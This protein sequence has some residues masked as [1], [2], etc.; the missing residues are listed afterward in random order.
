MRCGGPGPSTRTLGAGPRRAA[1]PVR[2]PGPSLSGGRARGASGTPVGRTRQRGRQSAHDGNRQPHA[3]PEAGGPRPGGRRRPG[4]LRILGL[5]PDDVPMTEGESLEPP[6]STTPPSWPSATS[7]RSAGS[8]STAGWARRPT[9]RSPRPAGRWA[10]GCCATTPSAPC[11]ATTSPACRSG[12]SSSATTPGRADGILGPE[13]EPGLRAFQRDYGLTS[14]GTCG[15]AT[16]RALRQ[17]GR[18]VTGG[19]PQLL[20][21]SASLVDSGPHLIG[22]RIVVDPGTAATTPAS[23]SARPP[24]PTSS[25]TSPPASRAGWPRPAPWST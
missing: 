23:P 4:S 6:C 14:D 22:R 18:K 10:T 19:R 2:H 20:R 8:P 15:P 13:T 25:S 21:Q 24:R 17:L 5:L 12:C 9:G 11:A 1:V 3:A 7:S 16:L